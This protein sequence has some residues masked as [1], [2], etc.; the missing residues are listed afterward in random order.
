M[1]NKFNHS[2]LTI[3]LF[4]SADDDKDGDE[5]S[6]RLLSAANSWEDDVKEEEME[7]PVD[8][9]V[10]DTTHSFLTF[11]DYEGCLTTNT[12]NNTA[13]RSPSPRSPGPNAPLLPIDDEGGS[14]PPP[15]ALESLY[16]SVPPSDNRFDDVELGCPPAVATTYGDNRTTASY[17]AE[18]T[19]LTQHNG[20]SLGKRGSGKRN[21]FYNDNNVI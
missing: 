16:D 8:G 2:N 18:G 21:S 15:Y 11:S 1:E 10:D 3:F 4:F 5:S 6:V 13:G 17:C 12:R 9:D 19:R 14:P 7:D 20:D